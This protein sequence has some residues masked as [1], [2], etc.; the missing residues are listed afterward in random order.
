[1][2][3]SQ[4][5]SRWEN[6]NYR[7][8]DRY[9]YA[10]GRKFHTSVKPFLMNQVDSIV[11][12]DT[13]MYIKTK[14]K[15]I[16]KAFNDDLIS[17][18][19]PSIHF[20]VNPYINFEMGKDNDSSRRSYINSRGF[21]VNATV[22]K[23]VAIMTS[24]RENQAIFSDY[25]NIWIK[26]T[27][28]VPGQ[29]KAKP[30]KKGGYDWGEAQGIASYSPSQYF[31]F[32]LGTG[33][34][35]FGDGY[36]SLLLSDNAN[37]YPFF[38]ITTDVWHLKYVNLYGQFSDYKSTISPERG[39]DKKWGAFHYLSWNTFNWINISLFEGVIWEHADTNGYRGFEFSYA[40]PVAFYRPIEYSNGSPDNV[41]IGVNGK[42]TILKHYIL[43]AQLILDEFKLS[44]VKARDGWWAN[45]YGYQMGFK[46]YDVLGI[47]RFDIQGEY[48]H[49]RPFTYSHW[50][51]AQSYGHYYQPL[52]HPLGANFDELVGIVR[53]SYKRL[54]VE[55]KGVGSR[56]GTDLPNQNVGQNIFESYAS[57]RK[58]YGNTVGQGVSNIL[59]HTDFNISLLI[60]PMYNLN[61][62]VGGNYRLF[63][64]S[65]DITSYDL[66]YV[67]LRT[68][69][70]NFSIDY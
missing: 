39:Y 43:Y 9:V 32:Q 11:S 13:I 69:L 55:F 66:L 16:H 17:F 10:S 14:R 20:S 48:N 56:C 22:G 70:D 59:I 8:F 45:K 30:F 34:N 3:F 54:F 49:V 4:E 29:S 36:R 53:Y 19:N 68:S 64:L 5:I 62:C 44:H 60:N 35:F 57:K 51:S 65:K 21:I 38:K 52:A 6:N 12:I 46:A 33:K 63:A 47:K 1:M 67:A 61:I 42:I 27:G 24:F 28:Y 41:L 18:K 2:L 50:T 26:R 37:S 7:H 25:R 23:N 31:N 58:E 40:N 15:L